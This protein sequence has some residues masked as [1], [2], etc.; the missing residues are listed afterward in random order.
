M[1]QGDNG[2][3]LFR[4][5]NEIYYQ[6][7]VFSWGA[8]SALPGVPGV[9]TQIPS[10]ENGFDW[11]RQTVCGD[12]DIEALFCIECDADCECPDDY[13]CI[14]YEEVE[15]RRRLSRRNAIENKLKFL[16]EGFLSPDHG[17]DDAAN[18]HD[19]KQKGENK[20]AENSGRY[21]KGARRVQSANKDDTDDSSSSSKSSKSCKSGSIGKKCGSGEEG[22]CF[23]SDTAL[24]DD[25]GGKKSSSSS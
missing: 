11:I 20:D 25:F 21:K 7:G 6:V 19:S 22:Y 15:S 18:E 10:N 17:K 24:V 16:D 4:E 14:C 3:P 5:V 9:F 8:I 2:A 12:W 1:F 13:E 23:R